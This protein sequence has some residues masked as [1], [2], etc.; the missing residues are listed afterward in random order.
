MIRSRRSKS[1]WAWVAAACL[2]AAA[3]GGAQSRSGQ[4]R[5]RGP[6]PPPP[7]AKLIDVILRKFEA[8]DTNHDGVL[9]PAE[10]AAAVMDPAVRGDD[11]AAAAAMENF[12]FQE[13]MAHRTLQ[14]A[15]AGLERSAI[16][17]AP[18][19]YFTLSPDEQGK[20]RLNLLRSR[21]SD[22]A[23]LSFTPQ[24]Y[25]E[26]A[27]KFLASGER[28]LY[29]GNVPDFGQVQQGGLG[30]CYF[31]AVVGSLARA[32]PARLQEMIT[33]AT[34]NAYFVRWGDG[35][36]T[37]VAALSEGEIAVS[38]A[39]TWNGL[40]LRVLEKALAWKVYP[41]AANGK[42]LT[43]GVI[44]LGGNPALA[45][46]LMTGHH[47]DR[48][49]LPHAYVQ[50]PL[51]DEQAAKVLA[52]A[53][54]ELTRSLAAK[55]TVI[56]GTRP[57][58]PQHAPPPGIDPQHAYAVLEYDANAD[59]VK[60]W[61]PHRNDFAPAKFPDGP[62][63]GYRTQ[64][65]IFTMPLDECLRVFDELIWETDEPLR[66]GDLTFRPPATRRAQTRPAGKT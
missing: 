59:T 11:A 64:A 23:L 5:R 65:G 37:E 33:E 52:Q 24:A 53:R 9:G 50:R 31:V 54:A 32:D 58:A 56:V 51:S 26:G 34:G 62:E 38:G 36:T 29:V 35:S 42:T 2:S 48:V 14:L 39:G 27:K 44:G 43:G 16:L 21:P 28:R 40:W 7:P 4:G 30:D 46:H 57:A 25:F 13:F 8:W 6:P 63:N 47:A 49:R 61:N 20:P 17:S 3:L 10:V 22:D 45:T 1:G 41:E 66:D 55:R 19:A 60:L 12:W 18:A 15:R